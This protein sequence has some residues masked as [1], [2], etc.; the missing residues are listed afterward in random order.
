MSL[1]VWLQKF[2]SLKALLPTGVA[3]IQSCHGDFGRWVM[4]RDM[5]PKISTSWSR[6]TQIGYF[7]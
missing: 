5:S 3:I 2:G 6:A 4:G 7:D 1:S